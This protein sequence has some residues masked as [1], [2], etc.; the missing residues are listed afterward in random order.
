MAGLRWILFGSF[1]ALV[2]VFCATRQ[3]KHRST[4]PLWDLVGRD[5]KRSPEDQAKVNEFLEAKGFEANVLKQPRLIQ[6]WDGD[7]SR[8]VLTAI[9]GS[10]LRTE[11]DIDRIWI[12]VL[13]ANGNVMGTSN[14]IAGQKCV[15]TSISTENVPRIGKTLH[16]STAPIMNGRRDV[17]GFYVALD[18]SRP[19]TIRVEGESGKVIYN[20]YSFPNCQVGPKPD[21]SKVASELESKSPIRLLEALTWC[22]AEH[23]GRWQVDSIHADR[24]QDASGAQFKAMA[25]NPA[26]L[27]RLRDLEN[28]NVPWVSETAKDTLTK[29]AWS[30]RYPLAR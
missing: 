14:F 5:L 15:L 8:F 9:D 21:S 12:Y 28:S 10:L 11:E 4:F 29:D 27:K 19:A 22:N 2:L 17:A 16:F 7:G 23:F 24:S 6:D 1:C 3:R 30:Q 26:I 20:D 18:D 25:A 13:D